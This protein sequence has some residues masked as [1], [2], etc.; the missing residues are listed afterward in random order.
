[1]TQRNAS[2]KLHFQIL[3]AFAEFERELIRERTIQGILRLKA[4]GYK[5]TGRPKGSKDRKKRKT[6]GY[7]ER[8]E[9]KRQK[10]NNPL[11]K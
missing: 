11:V 10:Q 4:K 8:E 5:F 3:S 6:D 2:G 1:L 9:K 7:F